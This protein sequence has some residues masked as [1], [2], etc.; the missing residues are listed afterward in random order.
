MS[1]IVSVLQTSSDAPTDVT[2]RDGTTMSVRP[3]CGADLGAVKAFVGALSAESVYL[4][5][6]GTPRRETIV[7]WALNCD[8]CDRYA[9]VATVGPSDDIVGHA[10]YV[11][12]DRDC[13]EVAFIVADQW[14]G[15]GIATVLLGRL[16]AVARAHGISRFKAEVLSCNHHMLDVFRNSG[17]GVSV[18]SAQGVA[19]VEFP[20]ALTTEALHRYQA[21]EHADP[22]P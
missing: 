1:G 17:F 12:L 18:H 19:D 3:V 7:G 2:L 21:R 5:F 13:A 6:F 8:L 11:R 15:H 9:L 16:A 22:S 20:T 14:Q 10:A 4:R